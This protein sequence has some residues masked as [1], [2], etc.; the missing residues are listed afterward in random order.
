MLIALQ[1]GGDGEKMEPNENAE[2]C[3]L[4]QQAP[5]REDH[6]VVNCDRFR[7]VWCMMCSSAYDGVFDGWVCEKGYQGSSRLGPVR[8]SKGEALKRLESLDLDARP[9]S[10]HTYPDGGVEVA[11]A[12]GQR[13]P[14]P[15]NRDPISPWLQRSD[16][17]SVHL[18]SPEDHV[19]SCAV[20]QP[21]EPNVAV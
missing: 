4:S 21:R 3:S 16:F 20:T 10:H 6:A 11:L 13:M 14:R 1:D 5:T 19:A 7:S 2:V 12:T 15:S 9:R 17:Y 8:E 18:Q